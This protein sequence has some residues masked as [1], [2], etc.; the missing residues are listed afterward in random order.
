[1]NY[2]MQ[3]GNCIVG[4]ELLE[5]DFLCNLDS[6]KGHCCVE[7]EA[8]AP[9]EDGEAELIEKYYPNFKK[10]LREETIKEI[11]KFGYSVIDKSDGEPVTP[12]NKGK[13]C[14]YT[15]FKNGIAQCGIEKE[16]LRGKIP[17]RKPISCHLYPIRIKK[18]GD[19][20]V[21]LNYHVWNVCDPAR[22]YGCK[23]KVKAYE[24]LEEALVRKFGR[25]WYN[26]LLE[27]VEV[28]KKEIESSEKS[29]DCK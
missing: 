9:L 4:T 13:E 27:T 6:C 16:F 20:M 1:M 7:G 12:L 14:V 15:M 24:F 3:V 28:Y 2:M 29:K 22:K 19:D 21:A 8:G 17:F 25:E 5:E 23:K 18:M 10:H 11:E 26:E